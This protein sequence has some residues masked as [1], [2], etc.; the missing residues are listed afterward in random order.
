MTKNEHVTFHLMNNPWINNG[1]VRLAQRMDLKFEGG[2]D[3]QSDRNTI[4]FQSQDSE[5][6]DIYKR[7]SNTLHDLAAEGTYNFNANLKLLN[8]ELKQSY[9]RPKD[10]PGR[11]GDESE[12]IQI[13]RTEIDFLKKRKRD[14]NKKQKIWK[15]RLSYLGSNDNYLNNGLN[16]AETKV[17]EKL[18]DSNYGNEIC[19]LCGVPSNQLLAVNQ[20]LNPLSGEHHSNVTEGYSDNIRKQIDICPKCLTL[21]Y[22]SLFDYHIPFFNIPQKRETYFALPN[23]INFGIL[24]KVS[25]NL[26]LKSQHI[27]FNEESCTS[28]S[29]NIKS[30]PNRSKSASLLAL[31]HNI[32]NEYHREQPEDLRLQFEKITK[33]EF[34]DIVEWIF[35][36][37]SYK[38]SHIKASEKIYDILGSFED[39]DTKGDVYFVPDVLRNLN[40]RRFSEFEVEEFYNG[41]IELNTYKIS[42]NLFL[43]TKRYITN[44][45]SINIRFRPHG[46]S[47]LYLFINI[48]LEKI[49]EVTTML[50]EQIRNACQDVS[51]TIGKSFS[52]DVGMMTKFAYASGPNEFKKAIEDA[53]FRLAKSSAADKKSKYYLNEDGVKIIFESLDNP[54]I[55][56]DL[57]NYFVSFMSVYALQQNY[58]LNKKGD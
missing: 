17:Y 5:N 49:F 2:V 3:I 32:K 31:I 1:L 12:I 41:I 28:Y 33:D 29:T 18:M 30:L 23:T 7:I 46:R 27:D 20:F 58:R 53:S 25:N 4:T 45:N 35:I 42:K 48:F 43:I 21:C 51:Q 8:N 9:S 13:G 26:C 10:Y 11:K 50:N 36:S 19:P 47:A 40:L 37:K 22:F 15:M 54:E 14:S 52:K 44:P 57:K 6:E 55:F 16:F 24:R 56:D 38:F 39:P 34:K